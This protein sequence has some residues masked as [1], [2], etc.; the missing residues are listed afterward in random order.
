MQTSAAPL[1]SVLPSP[2]PARGKPANA[3]ASQ[4][5]A[6]EARQPG[7]AFNTQLE[8][9]Q[10][11]RDTG[12]TDVAGAA[13]NA[14]SHVGANATEPWQAGTTDGA[15]GEAA[16]DADAP[17]SGVPGTPGEPQAIIIDPAWMTQPTAMPAANTSAVMGDASASSDAPAAVTVTDHVAYSQ[18]TGSDASAWLD[19][20]EQARRVA[21]GLPAGVSE[22]ASDARAAA[23]ANPA[24]PVDVSVPVAQGATAGQAVQ[25]AAT[26]RTRGTTM[27]EA[28][29]DVAEQAGA[30]ISFLDRL[31]GVAKPPVTAGHPAGRPAPATMALQDSPEA[32]RTAPTLQGDAV[33]ALAEAVRGATAVT[34][35]A[36]GNVPGTTASP[37]MSGLTGAVGSTAAT[38]AAPSGA[39]QHPGTVQILDEAA[40]PYQLHHHLRWMQT[41]GQGMAELQL[42]PAELGPVHVT[43]KMEERRVEA[44]FLCAQPMTRDLIEA[45]MPRLRE[46]M[47]S[48]GMELA[49]G[50]VGTGEFGQTFDPAGSEAG[51]TSSRST[52]HAEGPGSHI[53]GTDTQLARVSSHEGLVDTFA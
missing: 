1:S 45:A 3:A 13:D 37:M 42:N 48:A 41:R 38:P 22:F 15:T 8:Q 7:A 19:T 33:P 24:T 53:G 10:T 46:A 31:A 26:G 30:D 12:P 43:V 34:G 11:R 52:A 9:A 35:D 49:G 36:A 47:E 21:A 6:A 16:V 29:Q 5:D 32:I 51:R 39:M 28:T 27:P 2:A 50:F 23:A 20:L 14:P 4:A 25:R 17:V 18:G 44:S 40:L